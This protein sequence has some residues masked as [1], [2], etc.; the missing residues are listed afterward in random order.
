M[1]SPL[2]R[3][4]NVLEILCTTGDYDY[5]KLILNEYIHIKDKPS[6]GSGTDGAEEEVP[7]LDINRSWKIS[8]TTRTLLTLA[9]DTNY[10]GQRTYMLNLLLEYGKRIGNNAE[11]AVGSSSTKKKPDYRHHQ[12]HRPHRRH[13][14]HHHQHHHHARSSS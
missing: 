5:L 14:N 3:R 9:V 7:M 4:Q 11:Y 13:P 10:P 2:P 1:A 12:H 8:N 6:D